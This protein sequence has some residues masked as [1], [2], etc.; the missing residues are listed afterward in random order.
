M[1]ITHYILISASV[2]F[3]AGCAPAPKRTRKWT[4]RGEFD[5]IEVVQRSSSAAAADTNLTALRHRL[6]PDKP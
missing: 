4:M 2:F 6:F 3:V 1:P 5:W